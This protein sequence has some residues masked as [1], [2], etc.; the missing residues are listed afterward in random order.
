MGICHH[1]KESVDRD[2][3]IVLPGC[4]RGD[5][6]IP[7]RQSQN[8]VNISD[9]RNCKQKSLLKVAELIL[10]TVGNFRILS[11]PLTEGNGC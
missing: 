10:V 7:H 1:N 5:V 3:N 9:N 11:S 6:K 8:L 4:I 2:Y